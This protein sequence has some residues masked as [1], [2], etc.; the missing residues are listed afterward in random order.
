VKEII[1]QEIGRIDKMFDIKENLKKLPETPGVYMHKDRLGQVIYVGKAVNLKRRVSSYFLNLKNRDPKVKAMVS[2][3]KEFEYITCNTEMEALILECNLIKKYAP[4]YNV[5]LRDDKTYPYIKVTLDEKYPRV[6]KTRI[7]E[8]DNAKYFGPYSDANSVNIVIEMLN[9]MFSLKRCT[10]QNFPE[11]FK[12]CLNFHINEC[13]GLCTNSVSREEYMESI[14]RCLD[15]LS[16]KK[17]DIV[18]SI[19]ERME[20]AS[21]ELR[22]EDAALYRDYLNAINSLSE[23]Q[24][25]TLIGG[26]DLDIVLPVGHDKNQAIILFTVRD[27]K[28]SGRETFNMEVE[29]EEDYDTLVSQFIKQY[30]MQ[31][32]VAPHEILVSKP[33]KETELIEDYLSRDYHV[34]IYAPERGDKRA[35]LDLAKR[36]VMEISKTIEV[37]L[38][39]KKEK[40]DQIK[41]LLSKFSGKEKDEYRVESYDISNTNGVDTVGAMVV[42]NN[43]MPVRKNY[44]R[45]KIRTVEGQDDY[46]ALREMLYRRLKRAAEG[47][48]SFL[49]LPDL[50][51]MDGGKGQVSSALTVINAMKLDIPVLG[52]AKDDNHR[53]RALV[54]ANGE[55]FELKNYPLLFKYCGT[56]QEEVHRFAIEY[57]RNLHRKNSIGSILDEIPGI[58]EKKRNILLSTFNSIDDIKKA[59]FDEIIN[60]KGI[61]SKNA[62]DIVEF[63][64]KH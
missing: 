63:F 3:I 15:F 25:V 19:K 6:L 55:E 42:F 49:P 56:I 32:A 50:I 45:F 31:M 59:S 20:K 9:K 40:E 37:K 27:G 57:H 1:K 5:L 4:K 22:F 47:D 43:L 11:G 26:K 29:T 13:K 54:N 8:K 38:E 28:L 24:R 10:T 7:I 36:D 21:E 46:G 64:K 18:N 14:D 12:P 44:R 53:T 33:L 35:L 30:Y 2:H 17:K 41:N 60:I 52:M 51:L 58:G 34:K 23:L 48:K 61:S 16:G 62:T 39:S